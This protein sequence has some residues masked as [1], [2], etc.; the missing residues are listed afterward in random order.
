[1]VTESRPGVACY[2]AGDRKAVPG[3]EVVEFG[4]GQFVSFHFVSLRFVL[5]VAD[6]RY[7]VPS[8]YVWQEKTHTKHK[9]KY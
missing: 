2:L 3:L 5:F 1:M 6:K 8:R 4:V 7:Y 9:N